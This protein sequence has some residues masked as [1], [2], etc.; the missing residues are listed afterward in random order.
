MSLEKSEL[1]NQAFE[2]HAEDLDKA[3]EHY[4]QR[5]SQMA[6][7][8]G[9]LRGAA[10]KLSQHVQLI[11]DEIGA[12]DFKMP[13]NQ[14]E[15]TELV[16]RWNRRAVGACIALADMAESEGFK[17]EGILKGLDLSIGI[18][19]KRAENEKAKAEGQRE[20]GEHPD[21]ADKTT[22]DVVPIRPGIASNRTEGVHPGQSEAASRK[23]AEQVTK[24]T[25]VASSAGKGPKKRRRAKGK[26][27]GSPPK[28]G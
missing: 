15:L 2:S 13:E 12:K 8:T 1:L 20:A 18:A 17:S 11:K 21:D 22:G 14:L 10:K 6:G 4:H 7:A 23:E 3:R 9:H 27:R 26:T 16:V 24:Q 28:E 19:K 5:V 25:E